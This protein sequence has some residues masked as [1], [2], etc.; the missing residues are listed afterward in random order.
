MYIP[1]S[2]KITLWINRLIASVLLVL[3]FTMPDL[4][5]WYETIR[6]MGDH[7]SRTISIAFYCCCVPVSAALWD[8]DR[9]L[10][11]IL[12]HQVFVSGNV[13]CIR[14][15][16]WY[17]LATGLICLPAAFSYPPLIFVFVIMVFLALVVSVLS[18]VMHAAVTLRE[19]NDLTI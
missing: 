8:L 6:I 15:I 16:R 5:R 9:I 1:I 14:R 19:E 3:I 2:A 4:L 11:N 17:C 13:A 10:R 7:V 12:T 18:S